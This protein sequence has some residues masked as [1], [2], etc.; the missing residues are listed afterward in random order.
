MIT[1]QLQIII[2]YKQYLHSTLSTI[3]LSLVSNLPFPKSTVPLQ[4]NTPP[5]DLL[6]DT[7]VLGFHNNVCD[8]IDFL[9]LGVVVT[10]W[11]TTPDGNMLLLLL[12]YVHD[13]VAA[14]FDSK[15][16][17]TLKESFGSA[18]AVAVLGRDVLILALAG[19][20]WTHW[21]TAIWKS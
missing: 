20:K 11:I 13:M 15:L 8:T 17:V 16:Q 7:Y 19:N 3:W 21:K 12:L 4:R 2:Y 14:G 6:D 9:P 5:A 18:M 1:R 10:G